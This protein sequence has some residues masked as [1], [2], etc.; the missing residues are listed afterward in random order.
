[1]EIQLNV[2]LPLGLRAGVVALQIRIDSG[3]Q[4]QL[5]QQLFD[6]PDST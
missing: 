4:Q 5:Q 1:M 2:I 3:L 6:R